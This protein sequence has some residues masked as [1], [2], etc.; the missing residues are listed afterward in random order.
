M[1]GHSKKNIS[2]CLLLRAVFLP[3]SAQLR[4]GSLLHLLSD[5]DLLTKRSFTNEWNRS[6]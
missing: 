5:F 3:G 6:S 2:W 4:N 1:P